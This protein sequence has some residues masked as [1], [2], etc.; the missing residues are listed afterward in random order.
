[1]KKIVPKFKTRYP[2]KSLIKALRILEE[3]GE[4][5]ALGVTELGRRLGMRLS[6]VHRLL[7]T[8]RG[9]GYVL[10]DPA[11]SRYLLGG[12]IARLGDA[13]S[14]QSP[15]MRMGTVAVEEVSR[16]CN[17]TVNLAVL[18]GTDVVYAARHES[19]YS[20]RATSVLGGR[21]P[22]YASALGKALLA[23]LPESD[24]LRL[25]GRTPRLRKLTPKTQSSLKS[26]LAELAAVRRL[27]VADDREETSIGVCCIA[28]PIRG[29]SGRAVAALSISGP[30][31]RMTREH[32]NALKPDLKRAGAE[33][34]AKLGFREAKPT[35]SSGL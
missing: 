12:T 27:G 10:T 4:H 30:I 13:I 22:A 29:A 16:Q 35:T 21:W 6:T 14:R 19:S 18:D 7:G 5:G 31:S 32:I 25:Y 3:L 17:E 34:S 20:L 33:F 1:M 11:T 8:L 2:V 26:L 28:V 23:D 15:L 24:V 9:K